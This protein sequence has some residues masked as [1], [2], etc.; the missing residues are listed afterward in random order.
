MLIDKKIAETKGS[1][2]VVPVK[3]HQHALDLWESLC[4]TGSKLDNS[5]LLL[6]PENYAFAEAEKKVLQQLS[7]VFWANIYV[8]LSPQDFQ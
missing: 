8:S 3:Q 2:R 7:R 1:I 6:L 5:P 4:D